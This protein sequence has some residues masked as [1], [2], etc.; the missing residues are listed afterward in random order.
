MLIIF[1]SYK[2]YEI[3]AQNENHLHALHNII[4]AN[5]NVIS[6]QVA[7]HEKELSK[8]LIPPHFEENLKN[9]LS[10]NALNYT[11]LVNDVAEILRKERQENSRETPPTYPLNVYERYYRHDEINE[12]MEYLSKLYP[13][14]VF[15]KTFGRSYE[16]RPLKIITITNGD[17]RPNK[18]II[19]IDA[20]MHARE[21]I[22]PAMALYIMNELTVN[23]E[24]YKELLQDYDWVIMPIVNADGYEY[25]H[26][27][28]RYWRKTRRP[29]DLERDCYGTDPN[30]NFDFY[31]G[32]D[33]EEGASLDPCDETYAGEKPFSESETQVVRDIMLTYSKRMIW[34]L[35]LHSYGNYIL[36]PYGHSKYVFLCLIKI[37]K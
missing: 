14:R 28:N 3:I 36:L 23:Y 11:L 8:V 22:T 24:S 4:K 30:R 34:Y 31:W 19:F 6:L 21:W 15:V 9:I 13:S 17:G 18:K 12:N 25:T 1:Y 5:K 10:N 26:E 35:S 33:D 20:A 29:S 37:F 2:I 16:R 27:V 32:I 7:R